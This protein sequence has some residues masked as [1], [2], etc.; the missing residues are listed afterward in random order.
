MFLF[1]SFRRIKL[2]SFHPGII[3]SRYFAFEG[4]SRMLFNIQYM[5]SGYRHIVSGDLA[6]RRKEDRDRG[7]KGAILC[8]MMLSEPI[9]LDFR[10][11]QKMY[12]P[13]SRPSPSLMSP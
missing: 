4:I 11:S 5:R 6:G 3:H 10:G 7:E 2:T 12:W 9:E 13:D 1:F 8:S